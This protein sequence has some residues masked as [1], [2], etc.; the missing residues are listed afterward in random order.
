[1]AYLRDTLF[2]NDGSYIFFY[3]GFLFIDEEDGQT[4]EEKFKSK[5]GKQDQP[6]LRCCYY[7]GADEVL[8]PGDS[9]NTTILY[10]GLNNLKGVKSPL[11]VRLTGVNKKA[12]GKGIN[13][14]LQKTYG[15]YFIRENDEKI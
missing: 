3:P 4:G 9:S 5:L 12:N 8:V 6:A 14:M 10:E 1:M 15:N 13:K 2:D 11:Y 7:R